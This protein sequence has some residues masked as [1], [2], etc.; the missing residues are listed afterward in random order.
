MK[1]RNTKT[2]AV[3]ETASIVSGGNWVEVTD[4]MD[5][6]YEEYEDAP[7]DGEVIEEEEEEIQEKPVRKRGKKAGDA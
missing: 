4:A 5:E 2:G 3:I 7:F 6:E 1:Y